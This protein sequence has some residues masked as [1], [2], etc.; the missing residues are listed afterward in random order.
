LQKD[1]QIK[2]GASLTGFATYYQVAGL[3]NNRVSIPQRWK[4]I[5]FLRAFSDAFHRLSTKHKVHASFI[6]NLPAGPPDDKK[7]KQILKLF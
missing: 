5:L 7:F 6:F 1:F 2:Y 3:K 4:V